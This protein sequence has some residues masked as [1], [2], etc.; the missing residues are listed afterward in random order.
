MQPEFT[1][2]GSAHNLRRGEN[3]ALSH[4]GPNMKN[5]ASR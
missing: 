5:E 4:F 2:R 3:E 1:L